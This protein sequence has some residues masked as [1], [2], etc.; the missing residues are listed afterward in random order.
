[1]R[2]LLGPGLWRLRFIGRATSVDCA[3]P[4]LHQEAVDGLDSSERGS[5]FAPLVL[6]YNIGYLADVIPVPGGVGVLDAGLV[7]T[8][9]LYGFPATDAAAAVLVYHSIAFWIP[10]LGGL[11]GLTLLRPGISNHT[12]QAPE[13]RPGLG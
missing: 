7:G 8:L 5:R 11:L 2:N 9:I 1:M 12:L 3:Y 10:S 13:A 4:K 6:A